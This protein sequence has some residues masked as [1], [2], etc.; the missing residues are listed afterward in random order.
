MSTK[1]FN[2]TSSFKALEED[3][4]G[5]TIKGLASAST[6]DRAG[7]VIKSEAWTK[8]GLLDF[9]KNP[10]ILFNHNYD[11]PI[12]RATSIEGVDGGLELEAH[13]S[14]SAPNGVAELIK[15][16]VLG[17]FSVG[18]RIKDADYIEET[19]GLL[20]K[21]AELFE[22]S[23]VSVPCNQ[24]ATF[25]IA[26]SFDSEDEYREF[27]KT[28]THSVDL[29]GQSLAKEEDN[30]SNIARHTPDGADPALNEEKNMTKEEMEA[31][32]KSAA[33]QTARTIAMD[34][35][36]KDA[37][38]AAVQKQLEDDAAVKTAADAAIIK[39][40]ET[41]TEKLM[42]DVEARMAA[43]DAD[44]AKV[45]ADFS[46]E[47]EEKKDEIAR[48]ND[49]KRVFADRNGSGDNLS[50]W[51]KD[52]T[53]A[54]MLGVITGKGMDTDFAREV[55]EK[56]GVNY[57]T[58]A[59]LVDQEIASFIE[60]EVQMHTKVT[61]LFR[62]IPVNGARTVL[63]IQPDVDVA[64]WQTGAATAGNLTSL[65]G[66]TPTP[67][68]NEFEPQQVVLAAYRLISQTFI[69]NDTDEQVLI[70]LMPMIIE[71]VAR[72]HAK[73]TDT[74]CVMGNGGSIGGL[75]GVATDSTKGAFLA[76]AVLSADDL[77]LMRK[78]MGK[79]GLSPEDVTYIVSLAQYFNLIDDTG[80]TDVSEVGPQATKVKGSVGSV[81]G[82]PVVVSDVFPAAGNGVPAAMACNTRNYGIPRLRSIK[83]EQDYEVGNQRKVVVA[84][85]SLGFSELVP[86]YAGNY[87]SVKLDYTV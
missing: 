8:G 22:V 9:K 28:F 39:T 10:I 29:A 84:S 43:K 73:S 45:L 50:A 32:A 54:H 1:L 51:A 44:I 49:S 5:V 16:G 59:P 81:Y 58:G 33:E 4:G 79:Y 46:T 72:A 57:T 30:S 2:L 25:S 55:Q 12:G 17:A 42:A 34:Q 52:F 80:F 19:G 11:A 78:Q 82:S 7:D 6:I 60:K 31:I 68:A 77:L 56:A 71:S 13:I 76:S 18:F 26:K 40:L 48:M 24:D 70:N 87:S 85:Q 86:G 21:E 23:V 15:D 69:D 53:S 67:G 61:E 14:K 36:K 83:V 3:K 20:I 66:T 35:A 37:A 41:G 47:L 75:D 63:P 65:V 38:A 27:T 64:S 62:N 74:A